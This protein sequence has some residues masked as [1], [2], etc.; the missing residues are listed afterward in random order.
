MNQ[1]SQSD[2]TRVAFQAIDE[3]VSVKN[4]RTAKMIG[5][6]DPLAFFFLGGCMAVAS[7]LMFCEEGDE[8]A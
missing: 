6:K 2:L 1:P 4:S 5:R 7:T 3:Q 8:V